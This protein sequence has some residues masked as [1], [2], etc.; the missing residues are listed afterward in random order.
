MSVI[1]GKIHKYLGM[2]LYC[3]VSGI[4]TISMLDYIDEILNSFNKIYPS[5]SGTKC[6]AA[7]DNLFKVDKDYKNLSTENTK[8]FLNLVAKRPYTTKRARLVTAHQS[9]SLLPG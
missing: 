7:P 9:H 3:T 4:S 6:S 8:R 2:T 1:G 5:N